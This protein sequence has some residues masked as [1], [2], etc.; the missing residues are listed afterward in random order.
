V[1][2]RII[3]GLSEKRKGEKGNKEEKQEFGVVHSLIKY[4]K[5]TNE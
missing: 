3:E 2:V 5:F 1:G 4:F